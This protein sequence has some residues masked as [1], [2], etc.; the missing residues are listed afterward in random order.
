MGCAMTSS[1]PLLTSDALSHLEEVLVLLGGDATPA[2][3]TEPEW[4]VVPAVRRQRLVRVEGTAYQRPT[5]R[6][7]DAIRTLRDALAPVSR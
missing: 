3:L 2:F 5:P 6:A 4:Q 7:L 1:T